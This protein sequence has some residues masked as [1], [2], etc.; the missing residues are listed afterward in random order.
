MATPQTADS[1]TQKRRLRASAAILVT[2]LFYVGWLWILPPDTFGDMQK[3][4]DEVPVL[5]GVELAASDT[6][7]LRS[8]F[9][10]ASPPVVAREYR[11]NW[12]DGSLCRRIEEAYQRFDA[13]PFAEQG[14]CGVRFRVGSGVLAKIVNVWSYSVS[15]A[16]WDP[17]QA[18]R[19]DLERCAEIRRMNRDMRPEGALP[20]SAKCWLEDGETV[21]SM[22]I[23]SK[24]G[25]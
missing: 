20:I 14:M 23:V 21:L 11:A 2:G 8:R 25:I 1:S 19:R 18:Q 10:A 6:S 17:Q 15:V 22:S 7:G 3:Q 16:A 5:T 13:R 12:T 9:A 4:L 24:Q